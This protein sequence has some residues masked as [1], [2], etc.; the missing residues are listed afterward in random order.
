MIIFLDID[1]V[2]VHMNYDPSGRTPKQDFEPA[3]VTVLN[4]LTSALQAV[5]V[6]SSYWRYDLSLPRLQDTLEGAGV[7]ARV[8]GVT[9]PLGGCRGTEIL[10]WVTQNAYEGNI[11]VIDDEVDTIRPHIPE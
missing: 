5:I 4:K 10:L 7:V 8:I 6:I 9:P 1:G 3:C 2:L 11:I